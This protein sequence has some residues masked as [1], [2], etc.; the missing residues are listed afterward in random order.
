MDIRI[1]SRERLE[2]I[3]RF[4]FAP[5]CA[6]ISITDTDAKA[7]RLANLPQG[8]L[9]ISFDD[10]FD[11]KYRTNDF[12]EQDDSLFH[13]ITEKQA[14]K[15]ADFWLGIRDTTSVLICQCEFGQSRSAAVAAAIR[16]YED[17]TGIEIFAD[18]RYFPNKQVYHMVLQEL[19]KE[20]KS[21]KHIS[22]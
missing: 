9:R 2:M 22:G 1:M 21:S 10:V 8:L 20:E 3:S 12:L 19:K 17:G 6:V 4:P 15:I 18:M 5:G 14:K 11:G 7:V 16:E 13:A